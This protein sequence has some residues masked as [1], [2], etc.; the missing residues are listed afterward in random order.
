LDLIIQIDEEVIVSLYYYV[1]LMV[2]YDIMKVKRGRLGEGP[3]FLN[4]CTAR[5][6][7]VGHTCFTNI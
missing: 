3:E 4:L 5:G 7:V 6:L 2:K 1:I